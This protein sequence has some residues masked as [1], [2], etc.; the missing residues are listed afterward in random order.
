M[1]GEVHGVPTFTPWRVIFSIKPAF[2]EWY[3]Y[4]KGLPAKV[5]MGFQ[6]LVPWGIT[7][8]TS[9]PA[10]SEF[11][12]MALHPAMLYELLLN[13]IGFFILWF[14]IRKKNY[15]VGTVLWCYIIIYSVIR[16]FVSFF[17]AE[18]LMILGLRAPHLISILLITISVIMIYIGNRFNYF[19]NK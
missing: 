4:Y 14:Y 19:K 13:L 11:P 10:G 9:S 2:T 15:A 1:N 8:P 7:F 16:I 12:Y 5:R 17:R 18:D 3:E 6:E